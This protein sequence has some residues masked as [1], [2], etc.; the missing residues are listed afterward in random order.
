VSERASEGGREGGREGFWKY[1]ESLGWE[2]LQNLHQNYFMFCSKQLDD[3]KGSITPSWERHKILRPLTRYKSVR[4]V[5]GYRYVIVGNT[6]N[7]DGISLEK[8][9]FDN[10]FIPMFVLSC[11]LF[12]AQQYF[13]FKQ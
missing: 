10:D 5:D 9:L 2:T 7:S 1:S 3:Y 8:Y 4:K 13:D 12:I 11:K 6:L